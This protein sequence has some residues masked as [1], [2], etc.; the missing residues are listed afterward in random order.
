MKYLSYIIILTVIIGLFLYHTL[1][2]EV[3]D[4]KDPKLEMVREKFAILDPKYANIPLRA[5]NSSF[6]EN[7]EIITM[8]LRDPKTNEYY[9]DNS[10]MYV[11]LHELSHMLSKSTGH[12]DEF[13]IKFSN[14][15]RQ[16]ARLGIYNP[17]IP[18]PESYCGVKS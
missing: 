8:C 2:Y 6:T 5:G 16:A 9:D 1:A 4:T 3:Y 17:N 11:A 12:G 18:M 13:K 7:K 10:I 15:L 14:L